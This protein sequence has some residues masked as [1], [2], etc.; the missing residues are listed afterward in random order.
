MSPALSPFSPGKI[1]YNQKR[2][3]LGWESKLRK[4]KF[5]INEIWRFVGNELDCIHMTLSS[6]SRLILPERKYY[7]DEAEF[8]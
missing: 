7:D 1:K 2:S 3:S 6:L 8:R 5:N 4:T